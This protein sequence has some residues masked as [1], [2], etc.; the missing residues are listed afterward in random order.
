[1]PITGRIRAAK[2][3]GQALL[4]GAGEA[5][6]VGERE[7]ATTRPRHGW[8]DPASG[9]L[10]ETLCPGAH[11]LCGLGEHA[12]DGCAG[13]VGA[14]ERES[15]LEGG[16]RELVCAERALQRVAA[17]AL[18]EVGAADDDPGLGAAQ[19]LVAGEGDELRARGEAARRP[20][21][22]RRGPG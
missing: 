11:G 10:G 13:A 15:A 22:R 18:D 3:L 6:E 20:W 9:E 16:E 1:M 12:E 21:A 14:V 2:R 5:L 7:R 4:E 8:L 17:Q 19:Q